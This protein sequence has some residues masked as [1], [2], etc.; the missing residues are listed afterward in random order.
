MKKFELFLSGFIFKHI[1]S[2]VIVAKNSLRDGTSTGLASRASARATT[3]TKQ[4]QK[5]SQRPLRCRSPH[6]LIMFRFTNSAEVGRN[7]DLPLRA[8][9]HQKGFVRPA[10]L[11]LKHHC[12]FLKKIEL[13]TES[14][15]I[16]KIHK[17][18]QGS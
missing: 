17:I 14:F 4:V 18:K 16:T 7:K 10:T 1:L 6:S 15:Q 2:Q 9:I 12:Q 11:H 13:Q 8:A 3:E 5:K